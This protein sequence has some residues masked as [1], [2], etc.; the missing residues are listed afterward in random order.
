MAHELSTQIVAQAIFS[1]SLRYFV[2]VAHTGSIREASRNLNVAPS[3]ISR[4]IAQ[5]QKRLDVPLFYNLG[6]ALRLSPA[7]E[8]LLRH[9]ESSL[10]ALDTTVSDISALQGNHTGTVRVVT[11]G[12][13]ANCFLGD[14]IDRFT[15]S[16]PAIHL[17]TVVCS[18]PDVAERIRAGEADIGFTF[19][20]HDD[21]LLETVF[22]IHCPTVVVLAK[23]HPLATKTVISFEDCLDQPIGLLHPSTTVRR[24]LEIASTRAD[25]PWPHCFVTNS[26]A[27]LED[28]AANGRHVTYQPQYGL[29]FGQRRPDL[30][31]IPMHSRPEGL[32]ETFVVISDR[33]IK[34]APAVQA[35]SDFSVRLIRERRA[36]Q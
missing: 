4:Q 9:C 13:F 16:Y 36:S 22:S 3:A 33:R 30:V 10:D 24:E 19:G 17:E 12:S 28:L 27:L 21:D 8:L 31:Q 26:I 23:H 11:I 34:P 6:N 32:E 35:F 7:G 14:L 29:G 25:A 18:A 1:R 5:L 15:E 2:S 20:I